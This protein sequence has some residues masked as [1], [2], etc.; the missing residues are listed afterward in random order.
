M[1]LPPNAPGGIDSTCPSWTATGAPITWFGCCTPEGQC[2]ALNA[3]GLGCVANSILMVAEQ[4]CTYD[5]ANSCTEIVDVKCDGN[6]DCGD[7][8]Q[9]CGQYF[10]GAGYVGASC[11]ETESCDLIEAM[12]GMGYWSQLCHE[13][14]DECFAPGTM[15]LQSDLL[16]PYLARCR[17]TG[18]APVEAAAASV[19]GSVNC[20]DTA[21]GAGQK[22]CISNPGI[23]VCVDAATPCPCTSEPTTED[24]GN[25]D[26]GGN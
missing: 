16:P 19:S 23:P 5:E 3:G 12:P 13:A 10:A 14:D 6:E 22:C 4:S 15:C 25:T 18:T 1:C 7:G 24:G 20:G 21:C 2:G 9:C 8:E 17:D 26:D 11:V